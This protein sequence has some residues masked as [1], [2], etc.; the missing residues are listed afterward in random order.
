MCLAIPMKIISRTGDAG[1]VDA[2]GMRY[3]AS[4]RL[5]PD[6]VAGDYVIIHA[7]FAIQKLDVE[8][9]EESIRLFHEMDE[10]LNEA[11]EG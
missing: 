4:F 10:R 11:G 1:E 9:A 3:Q 5:L 6:A 2:G 7:G 8:D